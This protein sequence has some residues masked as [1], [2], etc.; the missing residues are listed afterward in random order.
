MISTN[1]KTVILLI[2]GFLVGYFFH[3]CFDDF[4]QHTIYG[5]PAIPMDPYPE[6]DWKQPNT[7]AVRTVASTPFAR[8]QVHRVQAEN[9]AIIEDWLWEDERSHVNIVVH[10]KK[11]NKYL[12]MKQNKYGFRGS[13]LAIVGGLFNTGDTPDQCAERELLE[14]TGLEAGELIPLGSYRVQANR[15]GGILHGYLAKDCVLSAKNAGNFEND[16]EHMEVHKLTRDELQEKLMQH[17]FGE[18]Q[19]AGIVALALLQEISMTDAP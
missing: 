4:V 7:L 6:E 5:L 19:H 1:R 9:G 12:V 13:K 14:E 3:M 16:Y 15:G 17:K 11:E 18:A 10:L 2:I 8:F